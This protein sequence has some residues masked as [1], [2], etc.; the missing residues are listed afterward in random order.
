[1]PIGGEVFVSPD[2]DSAQADSVLLWTGETSPGQTTP[3]TPTA[4]A[5]T[6]GGSAGGTSGAGQTTQSTLV[7]LGV[8]FSVLFGA[9][10]VI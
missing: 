3:P 9:V 7:W 8:G 2:D 1:M 10:W 5:G 6:V 4:A